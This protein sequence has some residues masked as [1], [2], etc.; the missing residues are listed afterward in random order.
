MR[1]GLLTVFGL[2]SESAGVVVVVSY[3]FGDPANYGCNLVYGGNIT[4]W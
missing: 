2:Q 4:E 3:L 1:L